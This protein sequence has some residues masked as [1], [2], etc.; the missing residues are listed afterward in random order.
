MAAAVIAETNQILMVSPTAIHPLVTVDARGKTRSTIFTASY[1]AAHQGEAAARFA[2]K[3]LK[4]ERAALLFKTN[5]DFAAPAAEAFARTFVAHGGDIVYQADYAEAQPDLAA[6]VSALDAAGAE[7]I[8]LPG[9][10]ASVNQMVGQLNDLISTSPQTNITLLGSDRG[11]LEQFDIQP[12]VD[13]YFTTHFLVSDKLPEVQAWREHYK[14]IYAVEPETLAVLGYD[15]ANILLQAIEAANT[16]EPMV[17]ADVLERSS[18]MGV[19]GPIRFDQAHNPTKPV[20]IMQ[21]DNQGSRLH[22]LLLP[23]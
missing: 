20:P 12:S 6:I 9:P 14:A 10:V 5:D 15:A 7:V 17:V 16:L 19:T 11:E 4:V 21:V 8:Y 2:R 13:S 18:F 3:I 1:P 22:T 23:E